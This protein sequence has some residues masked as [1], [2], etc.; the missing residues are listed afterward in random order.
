MR[1]ILIIFFLLISFAESMAGRDPRF[2]KF[3]KVS[4]SDF[5]ET[6]YD[7]LGY[8]AVVLQNDKYMFF[9]K[10]TDQLRLFNTYHIRIKVLKDG[11]CDSDLFRIEFSGRNQY[12]RVT[13]TKCWIFQQ[14]GAKIV[15][16]KLNYKN[17][18]IKGRDSLHS[19]LHVKLPVLKK[20]DIIDFQYEIATYDF[21]L[22]PVWK[23]NCKYPCLASALVTQFPVFMRYKYYLRGSDT[24][25]VQHISNEDFVTINYGYSPQDN[26]N[27]M[28]YSLGRTRHLNLIYKF[29]AVVD[30]FK[31]FNTLPSDIQYSGNQR[32]SK[33]LYGTSSVT[34]KAAQFTQNIGYSGIHYTAW[35]QLTHFLYVYADPENRYLTENEVWH[36]FYTPGFVIVDSRDWER[37][38]KRMWKD[39]DFWK[40]ILKSVTIP[41]ELDNLRDDMD[42]EPDTM[43]VV[44]QVY[45]YVQKNISWDSTFSNHLGSNPETILK[46]QSG[47]SADINLTLVALLRRFGVEAFP[48]MAA[49]RDYGE[50]DTSYANV[51]QFN[52]VLACVRL[53]AYTSDGQEVFLLL[54]ATS[55]LPAGQLP[56]YDKN[57]MCW[58]VPT[59]PGPFL[60]I[61]DYTNG[62]YNAKKIYLSD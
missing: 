42:V 5:A 14:Q 4:E 37:L 17:F 58:T 2:Q 8:D 3:G 51:I 48:A 25:E 9:D 49:T 28:Y 52:T 41:A 29:R 15:C 33:P 32:N 62:T 1:K 16:K 50:M 38:H 13:S 19:E 36:H 31:V 43:R 39:P 22:P 53:N 55:D 7:N 61:M 11:F 6:V 44:N 54:D 21:M 27:S 46:K 57:G 20:G 26:P 23:F 30:S 56:D 18:E 12:E 45:G 40:P 47:S 34:M 24:S 35:Q 60:E 59:V 10:L